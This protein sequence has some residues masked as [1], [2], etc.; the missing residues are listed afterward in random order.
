MEELEEK[1]GSILKDPQTMEKIMAIAQSLGQST[2]AAEEN[3]SAPAVETALPEIDFSALQG[4]SGLVKQSGVS[5]EQQALLSALTPYLSRDRISRLERAMRAA[6]MAKFAS[7]FLSS[8]G[9]QLLT[10]R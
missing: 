7:A 1:L 5:R 2:G 3:P 6:H 8:S 10:G 9:G 4:L